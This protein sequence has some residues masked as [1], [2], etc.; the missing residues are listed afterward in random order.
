M[1][2][3]IA[4][5]NIG[6]VDSPNGTDSTPYCQPDPQTRCTS[7]RVG[8]RCIAMRALILSALA[9]LVG[10][11]SSHILVGKARPPIA[12][13][14]VKIYT[15]PPQKFEEI[16]IVEASSK[17]SFAVSDQGKTDVMIERLKEEAAKL[18]AN[19]LLLHNVGNLSTGGVASGV[20]TSS[21]GTSFGTGVYGS[22]LH[23]SGQ[24]KAIY[25]IE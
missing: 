18:G 10:C 21:G 14:L 13:A 20:G 24:A 11:A 15:S 6:V 4:K 12:P 2:P 5:V 23:K 7:E 3:S 16:A 25:V 1:G 22:I 19:G 8:V 17:N 9:L